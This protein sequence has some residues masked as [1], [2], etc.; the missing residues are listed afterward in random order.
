MTT[1]QAAADCNNFRSALQT[2]NTEVKV[3]NRLIRPLK[4][5]ALKKRTGSLKPKSST[6]V[7]ELNEIEKALSGESILTSP[8]ITNTFSQKAASVS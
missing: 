1:P 8:K 4:S 2:T 5:S 3:N 7:E 6:N